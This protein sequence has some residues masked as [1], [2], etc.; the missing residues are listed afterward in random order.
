MVESKNINDDAGEDRTS[1]PSK[2]PRVTKVPKVPFVKPKVVVNHAPTQ[3]LDVYVFGEGSNA[4]L[5]LGT[6]ERAKDVRRPR[7]NPLLS[8]KDVGVVQIACGGM[9]VAALT[10]DGKVMT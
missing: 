2:K 8:A 9:H 5:G 6:A 3:R 1:P 10:H 4:E 7:L